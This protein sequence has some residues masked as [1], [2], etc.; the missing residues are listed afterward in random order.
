M[1]LK[2]I[3]VALIVVAAAVGVYFLSQPS[4]PEEPS[5]FTNGQT[6][7]VKEG[8]DAD[9]AA[10]IGEGGQQAAE[11]AGRQAIP[12]Q[13]THV[14]AEQASEE[15]KDSN[16]VFAQVV[17][18]QGKGLEG[19][20]VLIKSLNAE[21]GFDMRGWDS[22][23][24]VKA[25][26]GKDGRVAFE[27]GNDPFMVK[28]KASGFVEREFE[29][30]TGL[31][32]DE[33]LG[34][35]QLNRALVLSGQIVGPNGNP[36]AGA[37]IM[38]PQD[39][40][41]VVVFNGQPEFIAETDAAGR[42]KIDTLKPGAWRLLV[43]S[44]DHPDQ[45]FSGAA[46]SE[47]QQVGLR[48]TLN[49][50]AM[51]RGRLVGRPQSN[52][53][54]L[55]VRM[56]LAPM[57]NKD[58]LL[59]GAAEGFPN[60]SRSVDMQPDGTF[61]IAGLHPETEY[62]VQ[63]LPRTKA[64]G[65]AFGSGRSFCE[66][67][68]VSSSAGTVDLV[69]ATKAGLRVLVL[70]ADTS[71]PVDDFTLIPDDFQYYSAF[72][73]KSK[74]P[75]GLVDISGIPPSSKPI[76]IRF[77]ADGYERYTVEAVEFHAGGVTNLGTIRL[78]PGALCQIHVVDGATGKDVKG[79]RIE[80]TS[81]QVTDEEEG[82]SIGGMRIA[83][84]G[85]D[86]MKQSGKTNGEGLVSLRYMEGTTGSIKAR[87]SRYA[88]A[89]VAGVD[90]AAFRKEPIRVELWKGGELNVSV[91]NA[92]DEPVRGVKVE[93]LPAEA[94]D[95]VMTFSFGSGP[96][97][98]PGQS[99]ELSKNTN[100][101]GLARFKHV[102]AGEYRCSV[103]WPSP[104]GG[105][106]IM[107]ID[108]GEDSEPEEPSGM[109]VTIK[110]GGRGELTMAAPL[111]ATL[112]G[113]IMENGAPLVGARVSVAKAGGSMMFSSIMGGG[114]DAV[115]TD[116][117]GRFLLEN[118]DPG[119]VVV[120]VKHD[121]RV[122]DYTEEIRLEG[123]SN[124]FSAKLQVASVSGRVVD[125]AGNGIEGIRISAEEV[126][127]GGQR[128]MVMTSVIMMSDDDE[129]GGM[130]MTSAVGDGR[131][132]TITDSEGRFELRG[133]LPNKNLKIVA[134]GKKLATVRSKEM[135]VA[136]GAL[137]TGVNLTMAPGCKLTVRVV[138]RQGD[139]VAHALIALDREVEDGEEGGGRGPRSTTDNNGEAVFD[140]LVEGTFNVS[141]FRMMQGRPDNSETTPI[142][143]K[144]LDPKQMEIVID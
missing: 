11:E 106:S 129:G 111:R 132:P 110:E 136:D 52:R 56:D 63:L 60:L 128:Q 74:H 71:N 61:V 100:S 114:D 140:T 77:Q 78:K 94:K 38:A 17:D 2:S 1:N 66:V 137:R 48:W 120:T 50:G 6:E 98:F 18:E 91:L 90:M 68:T 24:I 37:R 109:L 5:A 108:D 12:E 53:D 119:K 45:I 82:H 25:K 85:N 58:M 7:E 23:A 97:G 75:Q 15:A 127:A 73:G 42:F 51:L 16:G 89:E 10:L 141:A 8:D 41:F 105:M 131:K 92:N 122:M 14:A 21:T 118:L 67:Q 125:L 117:D 96:P 32:V 84:P 59:D 134:E 139:P 123:G 87:H 130:E 80:L 93:L 13:E 69:W 4:T 81:R 126:S 143:V 30:Q 40:G 99:T 121:L 95:A 79:A 112:E 116:R 46:T 103:S 54:A 135:K 142:T 35:W 70:D 26:S 34:V 19:V 31:A 104:T 88:R 113:L 62:R 57:E 28:V 133:V 115:R 49:E 138:D 102:P 76:S 20:E 36:V 64:G 144:V 43:N 55:A 27:V 39:G 72:S 101:K 22:P 44:D 124:E 3:L 83:M 107:I 47:T 33:N 29:F 86:P 65:F 9:E